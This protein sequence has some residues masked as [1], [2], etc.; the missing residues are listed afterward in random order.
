MKN[1][2]GV[3]VTVRP[4]VSSL[5]HGKVE[6]A[7]LYRDPIVPEKKLMIDGSDAPIHSMHL[8]RRYQTTLVPEELY[9][10]V[11]HLTPEEAR[12]IEEQLFSI[13]AHYLDHWM[14]FRAAAAE[15]GL[16]SE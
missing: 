9:K 1:R 8:Q 11:E 13:G 4:G 7:L 14:Q 2:Q 16:L 6:N 10:S 12:Q 3:E 15:R 5:L